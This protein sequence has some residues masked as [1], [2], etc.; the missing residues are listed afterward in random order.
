M[1]DLVNGALDGVLR[2]SLGSG[3]VR[4]GGNPEVGDASSADVVD[5][6]VDVNRLKGSVSVSTTGVVLG[7]V[8]C[9]VLLHNGAGGDVSHRD[10]DVLLN[11]STESRVFEFGKVDGG[12]VLVSFA[13]RNDLRAGRVQE[14]LTNRVNPMLN[15]G[16]GGIAGR[17]M[18]RQHGSLNTATSVV[19]HDDNMVDTQSGDAIRQNA[20]RAVIG[21]LE[22]IRNVPLGEEHT[23]WRGKDRTL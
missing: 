14:S 4:S 5:E 21:G 18:L 8:R 2:G 17:I 9:P 13:E 22:L 7:E 12:L 20:N 10:L 11:K 3:S 6:A 23:R 16:T 15:R 19:T 1:S